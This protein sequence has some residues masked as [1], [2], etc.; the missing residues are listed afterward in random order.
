MPAI[1]HRRRAAL[2]LAGLLPALASFTPAP[3][4]AN[5]RDL[6]GTPI[7]ASACVEFRRSPALTEEAWK[8]GYFEVTGDAKDLELHCPWPVNN[9]DLSGTT[10]DNDISKVRVH[11]RDSDGFGAGAAVT[12]GIG[13][14]VVDASGN[15]RGQA[16]CFWQSNAYGTG[17]T[18]STKASRVCAHDLAAGGF[19]SADVLLQSRAGQTAQFLGIDFP[20]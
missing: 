4:R 15:T 8:A 6:Q 12:V 9:V 1:S 18:T 7:P 16:V 13:R 5:D 14:P 3:A 17:A 19:Y 11:Y 2:L 20:P 10:N